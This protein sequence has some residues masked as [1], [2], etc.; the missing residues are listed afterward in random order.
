MRFAVHQPSHT[1]WQALVP[2]ICFVSGIWL[3][4]LVFLLCRKR[5]QAAATAAP[6]TL[7]APAA[8]A[9]SPEPVPAAALASPSRPPPAAA[10]LPDYSALLPFLARPLLQP[11]GAGAGVRLQPPALADGLLLAALAAAVRA[12]AAATGAHAPASLALLARHCAAYGAALQ[13]GLRRAQW[14]G[15]GARAAPG[16]SPSSGTSPYLPASLRHARACRA[17]L[18]DFLLS[19]EDARDP[20]SALPLPPHALA[21]AAG[22]AA[23]PATA[24]AL[25]AGADRLELYTQPATS[26]L[27]GALAAGHPVLLTMNLFAP[28]LDACGSGSAGSLAACAPCAAARAA[29]LPYPWLASLPI[30]PA[31]APRSGPPL[32]S[33]TFLL[34]EVLALPRCGGCGGA[35]EAGAGGGMQWCA[36]VRDSWVEPGGAEGGRD[37]RVGPGARQGAHALG[38]WLLS[39]ELLAHE[40]SMTSLWTVVDA[41]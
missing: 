7:P 34:T 27:H 41:E 36:L 16:C 30:V 21:A 18:A 25:I 26:L 32:G 28:L 22:G 3:A 14:E 2:L 15:A 8:A 1:S 37:V 20:R 40:K 29:L 33:H 39:A 6:D 9:P 12:R 23:A 35:A 31:P 5:P 10:P 24:H 13:A 11:A 38:A 19:A 17:A 4:T